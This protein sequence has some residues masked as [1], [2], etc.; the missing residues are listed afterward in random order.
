[1]S[2]PI[3]GPGADVAIIR[4]ELR[5]DFNVLIHM[6]DGGCGADTCDACACDAWSVERGLPRGLLS[7]LLLRAAD[8]W[9][10]LT[11][12][13]TSVALPSSALLGRFF[14]EYLAECGYPRVSTTSPHM[15]PPVSLQLNIRTV[16]SLMS[17]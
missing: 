14:I 6:A 10:G 9:S 3:E 15:L 2:A 5:D 1:M 4:S 12:D 13:E 11:A 8:L 7:T 16:G 17:K